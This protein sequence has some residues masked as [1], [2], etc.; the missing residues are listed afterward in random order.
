MAGEI[1]EIYHKSK[2]FHE[3]M[4]KQKESCANFA[5]APHTAKN[6][7]IVH[8]KC[9]PWK[10][11]KFVNGRQFLINS[12][13]CQKACVKS[14]EKE[15]IVRIDITSF[16]ATK[17]WLPRLRN[18]LAL[19]E[20]INGEALSAT[21][22]ADLKSNSSIL[23]NRGCLGRRFPVESTFIKMQ[24]RHQGIKHGRTDCSGEYRTIKYLERGRKKKALCLV[25]FL[26]NTLPL[27]YFVVNLFES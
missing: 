1:A 13:L 15:F 24:R 14:F 10:G 16:T 3:V 26:K 2:S 6:W 23:M 25:N 19:R 27:F 18:R 22:L 9:L 12:N 17:E 20:K 8:D 21:F 5:V 4:K 11:S 7:A